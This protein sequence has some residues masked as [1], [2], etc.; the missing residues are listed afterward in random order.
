MIRTGLLLPGVGGGGV[1]GVG[2]NEPRGMEKD[3]ERPIFE[4]AWGG[5]GKAV[6]FVTQ[7]SFPHSRSPLTLFS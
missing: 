5:N 6:S 1:G 2:E 3:Q 4:K 7:F